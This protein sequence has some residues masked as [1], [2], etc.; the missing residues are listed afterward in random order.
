MDC[1]SEGLAH[2]RFL[3]LRPDFGD[4]VQGATVHNSALDGGGHEHAVENLPVEALKKSAQVV[5][6]RCLLFLF[7]WAVVVGCGRTEVPYLLEEVLLVR[8][9][10]LF[11]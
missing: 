8:L 1:I 10:L 7:V 5:I 9:E 6:G 2:V 4:A 11:L 3:Q